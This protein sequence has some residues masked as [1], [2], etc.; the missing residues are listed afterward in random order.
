MGLITRSEGQVPIL[1]HR[2]SKGV[3]VPLVVVFSYFSSAVAFSEL[4]AVNVSRCNSS[5]GL[6]R[7][8]MRADRY[9]PLAL[10]LR[11]WI[12][13]FIGLSLIGI[14]TK[15]G[16]IPSKSQIKPLYNKCLVR[17]AGLEPAQPK[18]TTPSR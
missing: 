6:G 9:D 7:G 4:L 2:L 18:A 11:Y 13:R 14:L 8:P 17:K 10:S 15:N 16:P 3:L 12:L 5:D 1:C